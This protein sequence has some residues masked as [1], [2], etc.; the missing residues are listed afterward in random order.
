M[1]ERLASGLA[2]HTLAAF[3]PI[4]SEPDLRELYVRWAIRNDV[5]LALPVVIEPAAPL[6]FRRWAPDSVMAPGAYGIPETQG[7]TVPVPDLV[8]VPLLGFTDDADRIGYGGG[9][10]DRT[11]AAWQQQ[12]HSV[13]TIGVAY[14]CSHIAPGRHVPEPHDIRLMAVATENGWVPGG[15]VPDGWVPAVP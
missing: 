10:Y 14:A 4:G 7:E 15:W 2:Q 5:T 1:A 6:A 3:W 12:G 8:L 13:T 11:L 9:Y